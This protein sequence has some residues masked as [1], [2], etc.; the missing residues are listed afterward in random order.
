MQL[1]FGRTVIDYS[2]STT[3]RIIMLWITSS[4][5]GMAINY[6]DEVGCL[7]PLAMYTR[8]GF[9]TTGG[10][11]SPRE[12]LERDVAIQCVIRDPCGSFMS[13]SSVLFRC[14]CCRI[15]ADLRAV[16]LGT[17]DQ[18]TRFDGTEDI[19]FRI[20]RKSFHAVFF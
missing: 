5:T 8:T 20:F 10:I 4:P 6:G 1:T 7:D 9:V 12:A 14:A 15:V 11:A 17:S 13:Y 19:A 16:R 3:S 2:W 18:K